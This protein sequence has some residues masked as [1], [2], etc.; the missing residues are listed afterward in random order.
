MITLES[1]ELLTREQIPAII[2][3]ASDLHDDTIR[4]REMQLGP[5]D[6]ADEEHKREVLSN[7]ISDA[8]DDLTRQRNDL[9]AIQADLK[10]LQRWTRSDRKVMEAK[11]WEALRQ[12]K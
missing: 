11:K 1:I 8:L 2:K 10:S 9:S 3:M 6:Y 5:D 12:T 4:V 7:K